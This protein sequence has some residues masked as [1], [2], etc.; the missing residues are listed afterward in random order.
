MVEKLWVQ[1]HL[2]WWRIQFKR[3]H[4]RHWNSWLQTPQ[5][6]LTRSLFP[7]G[8]L[9]ESSDKPQITS[10]TT[11]QDLLNK[12]SKIISPKHNLSLRARKIK[13]SGSERWNRFKAVSVWDSTIFKTTDSRRV[14]WEES[15]KNKNY[16]QFD[17]FMPSACHTYLWKH[18]ENNPQSISSP[19][20]RL[21]WLWTCLWTPLGWRESML[22]CP[23]YSLQ[24]LFRCSASTNKSSISS[25]FLIESPTLCVLNTGDDQSLI[26]QT[27]SIFLPEGVGEETYR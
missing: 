6:S 15:W 27:V 18:L 17:S 26:R 19:S 5:T 20:P 21:Q 7:S 12:S 24:L 3:K 14:R 22:R 1:Y 25:A 8:A 16:C 11:K 23:H 10:I 2:L 13:T 4:L 9:K